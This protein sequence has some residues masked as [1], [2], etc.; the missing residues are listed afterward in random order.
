MIEKNLFP[1]ALFGIIIIVVVGAIV[2]RGRGVSR[3]EVSL[4]VTPV[5][6]LRPKLEMPSQISDYQKLTTEL[7]SI[8]QKLTKLTNSYTGGIVSEDAYNTLKV[9]YKKEISRLESL[10][11]L[12]EA[13][14]KAEL[15]SLST[16][17]TRVKKELELLEAKKIV[18]D[19]SEEQ[20]GKDKSKLKT[21]LAELKDKKAGLS[22]LTP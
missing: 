1:I 8:K 19:V 12:L 3:A 21:K 15:E 18:G 9:D 16:E 4:A 22:S 6:I 17:E 5:P 7:T 10:R 2:L 20:Y 11:S 14:I 13:K